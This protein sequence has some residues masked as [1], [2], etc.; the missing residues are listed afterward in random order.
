[1]STACRRR[2][3]GAQYGVPPPEGLGRPRRSS[4]TP[5]ATPTSPARPSPSRSP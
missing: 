2:R 3:G 4:P 5:S 1:M